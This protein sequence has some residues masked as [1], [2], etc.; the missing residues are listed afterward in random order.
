MQFLSIKEKSRIGKRRKT[1]EKSKAV[2]HRRSPTKFPCQTGEDGFVG[3][4]DFFMTGA[5]PVL[6]AADN[7]RVRIGSDVLTIAESTQPNSNVQSHTNSDSMLFDEVGEDA[8]G[9][10]QSEAPRSITPSGNALAAPTLNDY[11]PSAFG[12]DQPPQHGQSAHHDIA[13]RPENHAD[14]RIRNAAAES[15]PL[16]QSIQQSE[17]TQPSYHLTHHVGGVERPLKLVFSDRTSSKVS[18][19]ALPTDQTGEAQLCH[20]DF[21]AEETEIG[22]ASRNVGEAY[23]SVARKHP[24]SPAIVDDEPW[25]TCLDIGTSSSSQVRM[26]DGTEMSV[27]QPHLSARNTRDDRTSWPQHITQGYLTHVNLSTIPA[28]LP[29]PKRRS[30]R[31]PDARPLSRSNSVNEVNEHERIW[32][33]FVLGSDPQSAIDTIHTHNETSENS[34]SRATKSHTSTRLP[35]SNAVTS[36]SSITFPSTPYKSLSGQASC[37]SDDVQYAPH[38]ESRAITSVAPSHVVWGCIESPD[39]GDVQGEDQ[40]EETPAPSRFG[41]LSTHASLQNHAS[42]G[43]EMFSNTRTSRSD[44]DRCDREWDDASKRAQAGGSVVWP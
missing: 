6:T 25:R 20:A 1:D 11:Q 30:G 9:R 17:A 40:G 22:H 35:L 4:R 2:A 34:T 27:P 31:L 43:S 24:N 10:L 33:A 41:K 8:A 44:L 19:T 29:V 18:H 12:G 39:K 7:I 32:Q 37:I 5:L 16:D 14:A 36:V 26:D 23:Q 13:A 28:S 42:H 21:N 38:S 15:H 3:H